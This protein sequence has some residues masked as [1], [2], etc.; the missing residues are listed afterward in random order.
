MEFL[1]EALQ[2]SYISKSFFFQSD[3]IELFKI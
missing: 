2:A 1:L 3:K